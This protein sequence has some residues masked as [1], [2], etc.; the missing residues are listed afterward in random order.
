MR[1]LLADENIP[2][3][4][5]RGLREAGC[6]I[7]SVAVAMRGA[8]DLAV[9]RRV[10][11]D[12]R[13]LLSFDRD[14][15]ELVFKRREPPPPGVLYLRFV[16]RSADEVVHAVLAVL[17]AVKGEG[18]FLVVSADGSYRQLRMPDDGNP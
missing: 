15:G 16:P 10:R 17:E 13:W 1:R 14:Y 2:Q 6:D 12:A 8:S 9:I 7:E 18:L 11:D 3:G 5:I 4:A